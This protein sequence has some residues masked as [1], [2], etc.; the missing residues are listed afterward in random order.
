MLGAK[1]VVANGGSV[2][3]QDEASCVVYGM[4]KAV[5]DNKLCRAV[6]PLNEVGQYLIRQI[7]GK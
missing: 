6:L 3:A 7:E 1:E 5:V 4:P 2:I